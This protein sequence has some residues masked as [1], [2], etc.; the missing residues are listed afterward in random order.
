[1]TTDLLDLFW[2]RVQ[3]PIS[4]FPLKNKG[5][6]LLEISKYL[7]YS[8]GMN[9]IETIEQFA[10]VLTDNLVALREI[11]D[12]SLPCPAPQPWSNV[13]FIR[14]FSAPK[15]GAR[16]PDWKFSSNPSY[17]R[18]SSDLSINR[19]VGIQITVIV[20]DATMYGASKTVM[21]STPEEIVS[22]LATLDA[23]RSERL[24]GC[25]HF[26]HRFVANLGRSYN[27]YE[28][29]DCGVKFEIDSGD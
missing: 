5:F 2:T 12:V 11:G 6:Y 21:V 26:N 22:G 28:C 1:M 14:G 29:N 8:N 24:N 19:F 15:V 9:K 4:P 18:D 10:S 20:A 17:T 3:L 25:R 13:N 23:F 27:R 7:C 16:R